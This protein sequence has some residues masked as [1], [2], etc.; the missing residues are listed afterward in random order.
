MSKTLWNLFI[1][2]SQK[3]DWN[4]RLEETDSICVKENVKQAHVS[5]FILQWKNNTNYP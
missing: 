1:V 4:L 3:S 2:I 5:S